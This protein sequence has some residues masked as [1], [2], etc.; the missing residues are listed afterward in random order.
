[1][2]ATCRNLRERGLDWAA[3]DGLEM[4]HSTE[5]GVAGEEVDGGDRRGRSVGWKRGVCG[6]GK[7][8]MTDSDEKV[9]GGVRFG[10]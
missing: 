9:G 8:N 5:C 2:A 6:E 4:N 1:M 7:K 3:A 10:C